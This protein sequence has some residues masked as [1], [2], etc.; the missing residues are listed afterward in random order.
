MR[1]AGIDQSLT[2]TG[3]VILDDQGNKIMNWA[4]K[5]KLRGTE[6]LIDIEERLIGQLK[7]LNVEKAYM[8]GYAMGIRGGHVFDLGELGGVLKVGLHRVGIPVA[9]IP[10]AC[11]KKFASGKG[12]AQKDDMKLA[13]F[14]RWNAEFPTIDEVDA[15]VI[16]RMGL[17]LAG[18]QEVQH[19]YEREAIAK[20]IV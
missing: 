6:R 18:C 5:S 4:I 14:K 13:V 2:S 12:N 17:V 16:A 15:Y 19:L 10:P 20:V 9:I 8:E 11:V 7:Q 3:V 1:I